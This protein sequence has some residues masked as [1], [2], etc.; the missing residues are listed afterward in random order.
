ML[1]S[2]SLCPYCGKENPIT[3]GPKCYFCKM[4]LTDKYL[5]YINSENRIYNL[6]STTCLDLLEDSIREGEEEE[7]VEKYHNF[8]SNYCP[9][10]GIENSTNP[11]EARGLCKL[12]GMSINRKSPKYIIRGKSVYL[13]FCCARCLKLYNLSHQMEFEKLHA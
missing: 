9:I 2:E 6:C 8:L 7:Y 3:K 5:M 1:A 11:S 4:S 13:Y 10:C 12:C